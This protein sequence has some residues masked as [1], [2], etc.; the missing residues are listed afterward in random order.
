VDAVGNVLMAQLPGDIITL[1]STISEEFQGDYEIMKLKYSRPAADG[2]NAQTGG[3]D[4]SGNAETITLTLLQYLPGAFSTLSDAAQFLVASIARNGLAP[5]A[6][7]DGSGNQVV[8]LAKTIDDAPTGRLARRSHYVP[9]GNGV[10]TWYKL[11]TWTFITDGQGHS[12]HLEML[13]GNGYNTNSNQQ[14]LTD[15]WIRSSNGISGA[16]NISGASWTLQGNTNAVLAVKVVAVGGSVLQTNGAW[17]IWVQIGPFGDYSLHI[18]LEP[19]DTFVNAGTA[20]ADPGVAGTTIVV[21]TGGGIVDTTGITLSRSVDFARAY[22]NK[23]MGNVPDDAGSSRFAVSSID[24][25]RKALVD[26]ASGH[27]NKHMGNVPDDAGSSRFAV[28]SI[29]GARKALVDFASGHTN[30]VLGNIADDGTYYRPRSGN[31]LPSETPYNGSFEIFSDG[32]I[33]AEGWEKDFQVGAGAAAT[34][35][36]SRSTA[37]PAPFSGNYCQVIDNSGNAAGANGST[38]QASRPIGV[39]PNTKYEFSVRVQSTVANSG[40][41]FVRIFWFTDDGNFSATG[42]LSAMTAFDDVVAFGGPTAANAWQQFSGVKTS[43]SDAKYC[44]IAIYNSD[45]GTHSRMGF[46]TVL[47]RPADVA[48]VDGGIDANGNVIL[49]NK[50]NAVGSTSSPLT[51]STTYSVIPEMSIT[52]TTKGNKVL[53]IYSSEYI[54][55]RSGAGATSCKFAIFKDGAQLTQDYPIGIEQESTVSISYMDLPS[56]ASHTYDVRWAINSANPGTVG[57]MGVARTFQAVEI[58]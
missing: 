50:T 39:R 13:S 16:P 22:T 29:D 48:Q 26:F 15:I 9:A 5:V 6:Q 38:S 28:S 54:L 40:A 57:N 34:P 18:D 58:G 7:L 10:A 42:H 25:A 32:S 1:D 53:L 56:A 8:S 44:R 20:G 19:S 55:S 37:A 51:S 31:V 3:A 41:L 17:E 14:A 23:H 27:S 30:K 11:G 45:A 43:P 2:S 46:D 36:Y 35:G 24:G 33:V 12:I 4:Q 52:I 21:A 47:M 49:K